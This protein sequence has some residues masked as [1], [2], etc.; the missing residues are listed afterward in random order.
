MEYLA[1]LF[2]G[3]VNNPNHA[4]LLFSVTIGLA[5]SILGLA[6]LLVAFDPVRKR[7]RAIRGKRNHEATKTAAKLLQPLAG[8]LLPKNKQETSKARF[9]LTRAGFRG[10][11][12]LTTLYGIK[13]ILGI[14]LPLGVF[15]SAELFPKLTT[16]QVISLSLVAAL[17]GM[18]IPSYVVNKRA[19]NRK[20]QIMNGFP[21]ALD[22][23]VACSEAGLGLNAGLQRVA[24]ELDISHPALADELNLVN[25]Q[26]QAGVDRVAALKD[27]ADRTGIEDIR[28]LVSL[29][30]QSMR[31]GT[32]IADTLRMYAADFRDRRMQRAEEIAAMIGTKLIFPLIF[33]MFPSFFLVA[34][35]PAL[36]GVLRLLHVKFFI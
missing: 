14:C 18:L 26:I 25:I 9:Q 13:M 22:L 24:S 17:F 23:L 36:I 6:I 34:I 4:N 16:F 29:L 30:A 7:I 28:G 20:R 27:L 3:A 31:F 2:S 19:E 10:E 5:V 12:A 35:G 15:F 33:C 8:Y 32:S 21:D 1:Q 11:N